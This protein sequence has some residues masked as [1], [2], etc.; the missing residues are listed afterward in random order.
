MIGIFLGIVTPCQELASTSFL[1]LK[2]GPPL[3]P[4][5]GLDHIRTNFKNLILLHIRVWI[6]A[7][8]GMTDPSLTVS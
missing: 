1:I 7:F 4:D 5:C 8:A 6:P 2:R 3:R